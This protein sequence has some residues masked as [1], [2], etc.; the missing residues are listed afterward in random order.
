MADKEI[1]ELTSKATPVGTDEIEIQETGGGTSKKCT[2]LSVWNAMGATSDVTGPSI[3]LSHGTI[4][5]A[6]NTIDF[7]VTWNAGSDTFFGLY[8]NVTN[9][10]SGAGSRLQRLDLAGA[11]RFTVLTNGGIEN[12]SANDVNLSDGRTKKKWNPVKE[13]VVP[14][15]KRL[16]IGSYLHNHEDDNDTPHLGFRA[17]EVEPIFPDVVVDIQ[18]DFAKDVEKPKGLLEKKLEKYFQLGVLE[19]IGR[20]ESL[21]KSAK[22][23]KK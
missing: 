7:S 22:S 2:L 18:G 12:Y 10:S 3:T 11:S 5:A 8:G 19:L 17:E 21:E 13:K 16:T 4:T 14:K 23:V 20:V 9:T 15:L 1:S 6:D